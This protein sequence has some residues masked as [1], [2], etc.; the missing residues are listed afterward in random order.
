MLFRS[1]EIAREDLLQRGPGEVLGERQSGVPLLRFA[2]LGR[3]E[4]LL[5]AARTEGAVQRAMGNIALEVISQ[6]HEVSA[7]AARAQG[8]AVSLFLNNHFSAQAVANA[9]TLKH[10]LDEPVPARM[11]PELI[12]RFPDLAGIVA[13]LPRARLI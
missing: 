4:A 3:D 10:M 7:Q 2:D 6:L 9:T 11:P 13:T 5:D 1:F 12:E 8:K